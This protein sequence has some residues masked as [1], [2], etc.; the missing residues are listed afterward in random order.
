MTPEL[1]FVKIK[2]YTHKKSEE[3]E[4]ATLIGDI[5]DLMAPY[6]I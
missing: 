5:I 4:S 6:G 3:K 2:R 1:K